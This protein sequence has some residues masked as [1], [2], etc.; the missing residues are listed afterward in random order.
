MRTN[1]YLLDDQAQPATGIRR[2]LAFKLD[3]QAVPDLPAPCPA[4]EIFVYA[5]WVEGVH[6]RFGAVAAVACAGATA[7][8]TSAPRSSAWSRRRR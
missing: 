6:L 7:G 5:P 3:P 2:A 8:R 4:H 1:R